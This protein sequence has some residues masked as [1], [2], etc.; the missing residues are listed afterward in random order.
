[1]IWRNKFID[2]VMENWNDT[3]KHLWDMTKSISYLWTRLICKNGLLFLNRERIR[4]PVFGLAYF[5]SFKALCWF[6]N[7]YKIKLGLQWVFFKWNLRRSWVNYTV[8]FRFVSITLLVWRIRAGSLI[9][10]V[11]GGESVLFISWPETKLAVKWIFV[12]V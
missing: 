10:V 11:A 2:K 5:F 9:V 1:M 4:L 12:S 7:N 8:W 3:I 6:Q